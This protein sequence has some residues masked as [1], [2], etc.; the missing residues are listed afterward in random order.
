MIKFYEEQVNFNNECLFSKRFIL[1][2]LC[3]NIY[4][5]YFKKFTFL[6]TFVSTKKSNGN[7]TSFRSFP[8]LCNVVDD[9]AY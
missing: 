5:I 2:N 1:E 9:N 6:R 3:S 7:C 4:E 8:F